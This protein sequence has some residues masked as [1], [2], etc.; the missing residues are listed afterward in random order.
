MKCL[1]VGLGAVALGAGALIWSQSGS[2]QAAGLLPYQDKATVA[3]GA[4]VYQENCPAVM[5]VICKARSIGVSVTA[6][7]A[8]QPRHMMPPAIHGITRASS[9]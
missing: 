1:V 2:A 4:E 7:D 5:A 8:C 9:F 3:R 6:M